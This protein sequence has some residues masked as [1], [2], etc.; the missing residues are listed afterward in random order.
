MKK[1]KSEAIEPT[2]EEIEMFKDV[3]TEYERD[4]WYGEGSLA[5]H[6]EIFCEEHREEMKED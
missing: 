5:E 6:L 1:A 2:D 3:Y 4:K